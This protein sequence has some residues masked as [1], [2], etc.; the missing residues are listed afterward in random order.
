[1]LKW[2]SCSTW[3]ISLLMLRTTVTKK[4]IRI[5]VI[6]LNTFFF[7]GHYLWCSGLNEHEIKMKKE[8]SNLTAAS[9][10][11][12]LCQKVLI[13]FFSFFARGIES[14]KLFFKYFILSIWLCLW[15][16]WIACLR[17]VF[18]PNLVVVNIQIKFFGSHYY[19]ALRCLTWWRSIERIVKQKRLQKKKTLYDEITICA[20]KNARG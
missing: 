4:N 14:T 9:H 2:K 20:E 17:C 19:I 6:A 18:F 15:W 7:L 8:S 5:N 16:L 3:S 11:F 12:F 1:M 13:F 10:L